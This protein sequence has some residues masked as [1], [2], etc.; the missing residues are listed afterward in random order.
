MVS[1]LIRQG[2]THKL[3]RTINVE[4]EGQRVQAL[5]LDVKTVAEPWAEY[6]LE[7]GTQVRIKPVL[8]QV[9]RVIDRYQPNGDPVYGLQM[10][11]LPVFTISPE[12]TQR[13][14]KPP[15]GQK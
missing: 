9:F 15:E 2:E 6:E 5:L 13:I 11:T 7:D 12:L 1:D 10:G 8:A 4:Y 3:A 14:A